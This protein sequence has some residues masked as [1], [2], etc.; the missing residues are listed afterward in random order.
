M[1]AADW[2]RVGA[3]TGGAVHGLALS[4]RFAEDGIVLAATGAGLFRSEDGGQ[5]WQRTGSMGYVAVRYVAFDPSGRAFAAT[6]AGALAVSTDGG[7]QWRT[8]DAWGFGTINALAF[9]NDEDGQAIIFAATDEGIY[10]SPDGG[11]SWQSAN[12]GLL[13]LEIL[14]LAC[15]PDFAQSEVIW[16][17]SAKGGLYRSRNGGRAWREAG[18]GLSDAAVQCLAFSKA[19]LLA[20]TDDGLF[21][22]VEGGTWQIAGLEGLEVNCVADCDDVLLAGTTRGIFRADAGLEWH[23]GD[24]NEPVLA[25]V[26]AANGV[27]LCGTAYTGVWRSEDRGR[28][29]QRSN[30]GLSAH[31]PPIA[32]RTGNGTMLL[33]NMLGSAACSD[34]GVAWQP[35]STDDPLVSVAASS[36]PHRPAF[37]AATERH[38]LAWEA[39]TNALLPLP[40]QP[41]LDEDDAITALALNRDDILIGTRAGK[42]KMRIGGIW[43]DIALPGRG[44]VTRL[45]FTP[46]GGLFALRIIAKPKADA[47]FS[48]EVWRAPQLAAPDPD[49]TVWSMVMGLDGLHTP[50]ANLA[51][52]DR[53]IVLAAH[54]IIAYGYITEGQPVEM[55]R[56]SVEP[57]ITFTG[58]V[59][60]G[61]DVLLASNRGILYVSSVTGA[62]RPIGETLVDV[63]VVALFVERDGI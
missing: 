44:A 63:P 57:G 58:V 49:E 41:S 46:A 7:S 60:Y 4:P 1:P 36:S 40:A 34:D 35:V 3:W 54:N 2:T 30:A 8:S 50:L 45:Q 26:S 18:H 56:I 12:F 37:I 48:A 11:V 9:A 33:A 29:W 6:Q 5:T 17:G 59:W 28:T 55:R 27:A 62:H 32:A 23:P 52:A 31:T 22:L 10:R 39:G 51:V 16:A 25:L 15:A 14:C 19:G 21:Q 53:R 13:D 24:L 20:G 47:Q 61:E 43:R 38:V 42:A